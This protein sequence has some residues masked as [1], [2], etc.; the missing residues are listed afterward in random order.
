[1]KTGPERPRKPR[2]AQRGP[3]RHRDAQRGPDR[4]RE[5]QR[6]P[7]RPREAQLLERPGEAANQICRMVPPEGPKGRLYMCIYILGCF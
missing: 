3:E 5:A 6:G 4:P 2:E 1:M 7:G